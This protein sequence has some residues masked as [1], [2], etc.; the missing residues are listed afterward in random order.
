MYIDIDAIVGA[1]KGISSEKL[2]GLLAN[3]A[4]NADILEEMRIIGNAAGTAAETV[5]QSAVQADKEL[6]VDEK[7]NTMESILSIVVLSR[8]GLESL[9]A[10]FLATSAVA[11]QVN[12]V[13]NDNIFRSA[14]NFLAFGRK[15]NANANLDTLA[16]ADW[17][18]YDRETV[19]NF[20]GDIDG[21][22]NLIPEQY[23]F[24]GTVN[25]AYHLHLSE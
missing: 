15:P 13:A 8:P 6:G 12:N 1:A 7:A 9:I 19:N 5:F 18:Q 16:N 20:E 10:D 24:T 22:V 2:A 23:R 17:A 4:S 14:S 11:G 21:R 3:K 25:I